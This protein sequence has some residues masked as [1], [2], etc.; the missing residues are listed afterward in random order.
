MQI[1]QFYI[2]DL[3][4]IFLYFDFCVR[5]NSEKGLT[6]IFRSE[7]QQHS[8]NFPYQCGTDGDDPSLAIDH[9]HQIKNNDII[10]VGSDGVFDNCFDDE[11]ISILNSKI[12]VDGTVTNIQEAA[13][14]IAELAEVHGTDRTWRSPFQVNS[15]K[16]NRFRIFRGGKQ[17]DISIVV[18]QI[19]FE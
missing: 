5:P 4:I 8:F 14:K 11:I 18:S 12:T 1:T 6:K 15:E 16:A 19:K 17:D 7:E 9:E 10:V 3:I 2:K 13:N